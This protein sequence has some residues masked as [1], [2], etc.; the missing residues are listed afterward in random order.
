ME[1]IKKIHLERV[2]PSIKGKERFYFNSDRISE[3]NYSIL[4][5]LTEDLDY[6]QKRK[7][8]TKSN[9]PTE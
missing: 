9:K 2:K 8:A 3:E 7:P 4:K 6:Y 5:Y 1:T